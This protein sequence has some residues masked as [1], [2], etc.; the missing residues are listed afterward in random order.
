MSDELK[1]ADQT[2]IDRFL[3]PNQ[4]VPTPE[5]RS[6]ETMKA[7]REAREKRKAASKA[8]LYAFGRRQPT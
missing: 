2:Y 6:P 1:F 8:A 5:D 3:K 7:I 4:R